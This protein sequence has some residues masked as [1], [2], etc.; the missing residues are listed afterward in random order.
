MDV[1]K[2]ADRLHALRKNELHLTLKVFAQRVGTS[3]GYVHELEAGRKKNPSEELAGKI[4]AAFGVRRQWLLNGEGEIFAGVKE[5]SPAYGG[6]W[7]TGGLDYKA[8]FF[9]CLENMAPNKVIE[10]A[11]AILRDESKS[12]DQRLQEV[13]EIKPIIDRKKSEIE[14]QILESRVSK[15]QTS[16][17]KGKEVAS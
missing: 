12:I 17:S 2:F 13:N 16:R 4:C 15:D 6:R 1:N 7:G 8:L 9:S 11:D 3:Q 14:S 10:L 5:E